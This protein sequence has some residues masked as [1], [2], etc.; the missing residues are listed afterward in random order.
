M[1]DART[2]STDAGSSVRGAITGMAAAQ[3]PEILEA[4]SSAA[5]EGAPAGEESVVYEEGGRAVSLSRPQDAASGLVGGP[6]EQAG[7]VVGGHSLVTAVGNDT[8]LGV[9]VQES[10]GME[11]GPPDVVGG[12]AEEGVPVKDDGAEEYTDPLRRQRWVFHDLSSWWIS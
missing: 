1:S 9:A 2:A 11:E 6:V 3:P 10:H 7:G 12:S 5:G 8:A 4:D